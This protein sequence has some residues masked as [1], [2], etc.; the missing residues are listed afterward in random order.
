MTRTRLR[1]STYLIVSIALL[2][3]LRVDPSFFS[4]L[5]SDD[6]DTVYAVS[7]RYTRLSLLRV[8]FSFDVL[9]L[10]SSSCVC[11]FVFPGCRAE[12]LED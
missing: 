5:V 3:L 7:C 1:L 4:G 11:S 8:L 9:R 12:W 6:V 2:R 10:R